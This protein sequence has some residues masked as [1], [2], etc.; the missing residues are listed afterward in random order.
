MTAWSI[1]WPFT[2]ILYQNT[3]RPNRLR[4][5]DTSGISKLFVF[6]RKLMYKFLLFRHSLIISNT[7]RLFNILCNVLIICLVQLITITLALI[8]QVCRKMI[9]MKPQ[10]WND[11]ENLRI[12]SIDAFDHE[13]LSHTPTIHMWKADVESQ[14]MLAQYFFGLPI[15]IKSFLFLLF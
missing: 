14:L 2:I 3:V 12:N 1:Y 15:L 6:H 8:S 11:A 5:S 10:E 7:P 9:N 13:F 4:F